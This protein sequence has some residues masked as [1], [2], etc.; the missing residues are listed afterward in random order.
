[1]ENALQLLPKITIRDSAVDAICHGANL[2]APGILNLET[3]INPKTTILIQTQKNE[4]VALA[5]ATKTTEET[6]KMNH[7]IIAKTER[8]LMPRGTYP[9]TWRTTKT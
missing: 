7:G 5:K 1:M 2:A 3:N 4:A 8:V 6:L 9:K